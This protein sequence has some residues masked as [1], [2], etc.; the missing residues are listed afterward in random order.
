[1]TAIGYKTLIAVSRSRKFAAMCE[2][3]PV[4]SVEQ[5]RRIE[6]L[7]RWRVRSIIRMRR[8]SRVQKTVVF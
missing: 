8:G 7:S 4:R 2:I 1:M 5:G 3:I 6:L